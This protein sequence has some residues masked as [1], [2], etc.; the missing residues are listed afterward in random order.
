MSS[1]R[2]T[3][4]PEDVAEQLGTS[5]WW[6]REQARRGRIPHLRL[7]KARIRFLQEHIDT[8]IQH[9]TVE[10]RSLTAEPPPTASLDLTAL[11][12]TSRSLASHRRRPHVQ[13]DSQLF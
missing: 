4:S 8:L 13:G 5:A 2:L 7:G 11:G 6:V 3:F 12:A 1:E 10:E 9:F